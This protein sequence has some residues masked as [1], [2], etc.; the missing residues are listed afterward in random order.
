[1]KP[2]AV[3]LAT[4]LLLVGLA[5]AVRGSSLA[6][7]GRSAGP[8]PAPDRVEAEARWAGVR[9][10]TFA[11]VWNTVNAAYF[12]P[13]FG[14]VDW[15]AVK[16]QYQARLGSVKDKPALRRL[17]WSMLGELQRTHFAILPREAA[18]FEVKDRGKAGVVGLDLAPVGGQVTVAGVTAG[19]PADKAGLK[20]GMIITAVDGHSLSRFAEELTKLKVPELRRRLYPTGVAQRRLQGPVGSKVEVGYCD[21]R[22]AGHTVELA[23]VMFT[24]RWS[25]PIGSFPS[26]P[27]KCSL[28]RG[29][30]G[31]AVMR[32]NVFTPLIMRE[33]KKFLL[34]LQSG[35][36]L[37]IDLR[38]NP[39]GVTLM[40]SGLCG[41]LTSREF[42]LGTEHLRMGLNRFIVYPQEGAFL[43]PV[44]VLIDHRSASTSEIMAAGLQETGR[45]RV[46][47]VC[48]AGAALPSQ[49][50][51]L[52]DGD[53]LQ[54]AIADVTT[55]QGMV[56]EGRGVTP[57]QIVTTTQADLR[58]GRDPV[59]EAAKAWLKLARTEMSA[60]Q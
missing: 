2:V 52:P 18:V 29:Q 40:A 13:T 1:M 5:Q 50:K 59:L 22:G 33:L 42:S 19:S 4:A 28:K 23:R 21:A 45:A 32:F 46:F 55:P 49:F 51:K 37:V 44:A 16:V 9:D 15:Q 36:G 24:G 56:L 17:L 41:W 20:P 43:G 27:V 8:A 48:S 10:A 39:G 53:I 47:G 54:Y 30:D 25:K 7:Q 35:D 12:D 26:E 57:D 14:G 6:E 11:V 34:S 60:S 3:R 31:L 38:G 58:A